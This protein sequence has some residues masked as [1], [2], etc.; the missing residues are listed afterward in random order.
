MMEPKT[1]IVTRP[2]FSALAADGVMNP[3]P[4]SRCEVLASPHNPTCIRCFEKNE[5]KPN[6]G[7]SILLITREMHN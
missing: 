5:A 3:F 7:D 2:P 4:L 6:Q 1:K